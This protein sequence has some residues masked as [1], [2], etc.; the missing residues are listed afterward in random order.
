VRALLFEMATDAIDRIDFHRAH[1]VADIHHAN[2]VKERHDR[3][4]I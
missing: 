1:M 4:R 2:R 3:F